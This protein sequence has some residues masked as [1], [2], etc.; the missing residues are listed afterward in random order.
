MNY[1]EKKAAAQLTAPEA[2]MEQ[3]T[4][5]QTGGDRALVRCPTCAQMRP[6]F[7][8]FETTPAERAAYPGTATW[9]C[10]GERSRW[11]RGL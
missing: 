11:A 2:A 6:G 4:T 8:V 3:R 10:D 1:L 7:A 5:A 9:A